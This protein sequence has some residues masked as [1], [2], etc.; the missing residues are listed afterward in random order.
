M[1]FAINILGFTM[2]CVAVVMWI[3]QA[4]NTWRMRH[5]RQALQGIS[6][7]TQVLL[8]CNAIGW[9]LYGLATGALWVGAPSIINLPLAIITIIIVHRSRHPKPEPVPQ[10]WCRIHNRPIGHKL[11]CTWPAG[12]G[13]ILE[14][15]GH[16]DASHYCTWGDSNSYADAH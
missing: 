1:T 12:Y 7:G 16:V 8:A 10:G 5:D 9:V 14:C 6:I 13:T 11:F 2:S 3:P 15:N 4:S